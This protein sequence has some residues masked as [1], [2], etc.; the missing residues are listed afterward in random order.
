MKTVLKILCFSG[1]TR[2]VR[3]LIVLQTVL[4]NRELTKDCQPRRARDET[5]RT[6]VAL[7]NTS[8]EESRKRSVKKCDD[9]QLYI[10]LENI[11]IY[12]I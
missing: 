3:A 2:R 9:G 11:Y 1:T 12:Y 7:R 4:M 5:N 8:A 10:N 6:R